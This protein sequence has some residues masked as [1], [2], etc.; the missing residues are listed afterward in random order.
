MAFH[1]R[2]NNGILRKLF[3]R[4]EDPELTEV[5]REKGFYSDEYVNAFKARRQKL[6]SDDHFTLC[7]IYTEME[8]YDDAQSELLS[9]KAG[10]ILDDITT[11]QRAFCRIAIAF[12]T[13]KYEDALRVYEE[14]GRFLDTF[15]KN[16]VRSRVAGDYYFYSAA[17][18]AMFTDEDAKK[19]QPSATEKALASFMGTSPT[20]VN[21]EKL[22]KYLAR[23]REWCDIYPKHRIL[24]D[25][26]EVAVLFAKS[27]ANTD[28]GDT[29]EINEGVR[30]VA[31]RKEAE[32]AAAKCRQN[33]LDFSGF[34]YEWEREYY[35]RKLDRATRLTHAA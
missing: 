3:G 1:S 5:F 20:G 22:E 19:A 15:M 14:L 35:L 16:P 29:T 11:G 17:L 18:C 10:S 21:S 27:K 26:T 24:Y 28:S 2:N 6:S 13:G 34:K 9:V 31:Y 32:D 12:G 25:I 33:I 30:N 23:L 7:E 4:N 8:R